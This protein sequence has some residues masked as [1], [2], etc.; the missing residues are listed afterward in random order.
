MPN[1][2]RFKRWGRTAA[3]GL[4]LGALSACDGLLEVDLPHLLTD[5]ALAGPET[6]TT[7]VNSAIALFE[8]GS[9]AFGMVSLGHEDVIESVAGI[10]SGN[11]RYRST[12]DTGGSCDGSSS[13]GN[14]F[15]QLMGAR[16]AISRDINVPGAL[17]NDRGVYDRIQ[18]EWKLG[19]AGEKL[20]A[21]SAIYMGAIM[22]HFGEFYCEI[23]FDGSE[24]LGPDA[25]LAVGEDWITNR[26][27]GHIA[28]QGGDFAMPFGIATSATDMAIGIRARL[29]W[30]RR[31]YAT[32]AADANGITTTSWV[33]RELGEQRRNKIFHYHTEVSFGGM[34]G[35][36]NWWD[37]TQFRV[38]PATGQTWPS[39]IP[40]SGYIF[41][42][43]M[44]DGRAIDAGGNAITWAE[45]LRDA[46][47]VP[48]SQA[49]G[50]VPDDRVKHIFKSI[51]GPVKREAPDK[52][53]AQ[54][55]DIPLVSAE[56]LR[57]IE[58]DGAL[59]AGN[60]AGVISLVNGLRTAA[61][62]INISGAY[63]TTLL[64]SAAE[65]R[66]M[67]IEEWRRNMFSAGGRYWSV[68]I[69]NTD[70]LWFPRNEGNTPF[71]GYTIGGGVRLL[72]AGDEYTNNDNWNA[73]GGED[74]EATG[75][76][77]LFGSQAPDISGT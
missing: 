37:G 71:Q 54:D 47:E 42:G 58:A 73:A 22:A 77:S 9:S 76:T 21:I 69:Q 29:R 68:K 43:V 3:L 4:L 16:A 2:I 13:N 61:G 20:S 23:A 70:L 10:G 65:T 33:T 24:L 8:C 50:A 5:A 36:N 55:D 75:C 57:L 48:I 30:A 40:F 56:E 39:P 38:N 17:G 46:A 72:F 28:A 52:Y 44:P 66:V 45:E 25:V 11:A 6:A 1:M 49:N 59:A 27:I 19:T 63:E 15:D 41:L 35:P 18:G 14:W 31:Q 7:Q 67:L 34:Y 26:A 74:L 60:L 51:Q 12:P 53:K 64:G 32:A 62:V